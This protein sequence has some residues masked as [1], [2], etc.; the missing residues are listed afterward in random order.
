M[1]YADR[2]KYVVALGL[3]AALATP[4]AADKVKPPRFDVAVT[5]KGFEPATITVPAKTP[6]T[7]VFTRKTEATCTKSVIVTL[8]DGKKLERELPLDKAVAIDVTFAKAGTLGY[9]CGMDMTKGVIV[10]R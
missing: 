7:L 8:D 4:V 9:A 1:T 5:A 6:V 10:V 3:A 2:M